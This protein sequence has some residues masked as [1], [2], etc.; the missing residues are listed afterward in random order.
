MVKKYTYDLFICFA[1][2]EESWVEGFLIPE[3][4]IPDERIITR[5]NFRAGADK[6]VE[7]ERVVKNSRYVLL[8]LSPAFLTDIWVSYGER[9]A[10]YSRIVQQRD[11]LIPLI[12]ESCELPLR[13]DVIEPLNCTDET[14]WKGEIARLRQLL[15]LPEPP[16]KNIPCPYP[17][18]KPFTEDNH[19]YFCGREGE[20]NKLLNRLQKSQFLAF[21]GPSGSGKSSLVRAGLVPKLRQ[22]APGKWLVKIARPG[23]SP[24][25]NLANV[26]GIQP[27]K[28]TGDLSQLPWEVH[29]ILDSHGNTESFESLLLVIDQFEEIFA[30]DCD[31]E[32]E[33]RPFQDALSRLLDSQNCYIILT[34]RVDFYANLMSAPIWPK[35]EQNRFE[36]LPLNE[37]GLRDAII[38]PANDVGVS[39]EQELVER[40]IADAKDQP[41]ILPLLQETMVELWNHL[42]RRFLPATAYKNLE[43]SYSETEISI[44]TQP[45]GL[46]IAIANHAESVWRKL[47]QEE[48]K[49]AR[50]IFLRLVQFGEGRTD[51]RRQQSI[52]QLRV[53]DEKD[54]LFENTLHHLT[55]T[56]SRL[57]TLTVDKDFTTKVD[58]AHEALIFGWPTLKQWIYDYG[59][60]ESEQNRRQ[61]MGKSQNWMN[62]HRKGGLLDRVELRKA[63]EWLDS[64][65]AEIL[66]RDEILLEFIKASKKA[67]LTGL[68]RNIVATVGGLSIATVAL[69]RQ[70]DLNNINN[71][72]NASK[73]HFSE[74]QQLEALKNS[75]QAGQKLKFWTPERVRLQT[76][77]TLAKV[78]YE[79]SEVHRLEG[80]LKV[81]FSPDGNLGFIRD[82]EIELWSKDG[83]LLNS[84]LQN[85]VGEIN[86]FSF[87]Q[88]NDLIVSASGGL[89]S[90]LLSCPF[91]SPGTKSGI[92]CGILG[93]EDDSAVDV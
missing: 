26:L 41:G 33:A 64:E 31:Q 79:I 22:R 52:A 85:D 62:L 53:A 10:S 7:F 75:I 90:G 2:S 16:L 17:G 92:G 20:V 70:I 83:K 59:Y 46:Q 8:V 1:N 65:N 5:E 37:N 57:L 44:G 30:P 14:R 27:S 77:A 4:G 50:R 61:L 45:S 38:Q 11:R 25:N 68:V 89:I 48:Q 87:S 73:N 49:I 55:N 74:N 42:Q 86:S 13:L 56:E 21:I 39:I 29:Q 35:V 91:E 71:L 6:V 36:V 72:T 43:W 82:K 93:N 32:Q 23:A 78:V 88:N 12:W 80:K 24:L 76:I 19:K 63:Q 84:L 34:V 66:G 69:W 9:I 58:I 28:L 47:S 40:L 18:L 3:L 15:E 67:H 54:S 81:S 60:K 51:T